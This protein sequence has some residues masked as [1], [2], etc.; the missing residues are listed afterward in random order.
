MKESAIGIV[1]G[2]T[3]QEIILV[4]RR[5]VPIWVL[6]G[7]GIDSGES[8]ED[9]VVREVFEETGLHVRVIRK[10]GEYTPLNRLS[11]LTHVFECERFGGELCVTEETRGAQ[12]FSRDRLPSSF[13]FV[14]HDWLKD[15]DQNKTSLVKKPISQVT[16]WNL[17]K[18]FIKH[19]LLVLRALIARIGFPL[20]T[21]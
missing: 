9:A 2:A 14:H 20:N 4:K 13:F 6:P 18:F 8:P 5:D 12:S 1:H 11:A 3:P 19:P 17:F 10:T 21:R 15:A 16:Y 7:G